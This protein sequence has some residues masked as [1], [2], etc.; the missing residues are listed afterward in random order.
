MGSLGESW[1]GFVVVL[2]EL[3]GAADAEAAGAADEDAGGVDAAGAPVSAGALTCL[4]SGG[5]LMVG[6]SAEGF[7]A[8]AFTCGG[9]FEH[10]TTAGPRPTSTTP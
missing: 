5:A 8:G 7:S 4:G 1:G 10:A 3:V 6:G 2:P 9:S